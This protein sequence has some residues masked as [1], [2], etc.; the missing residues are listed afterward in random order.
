M[1]GGV[2][3]AGSGKNDFRSTLADEREDADSGVAES[4]EASQEDAGHEGGQVVNV[5]SGNGMVASGKDSKTMPSLRIEA[6]VQDRGWLEPV[7]AG[8]VAG[9]TGKNLNL[10][11]LGVYLDGAPG[12]EVMIR[13]HVS[14]IGWQDWIN[15]GEAAGTVGKNLPIEA[16]QISLTGSVM[17]EFDVWYRVHSADFDWGGW[18]SSGASAGSQGFAKATQTVET[19]L[20]PKGRG[21]PGDTANAI[22]APTV[23]WS[24]YNSAVGWSGSKSTSATPSFTLGT[25]GRSRSLEA[26]T[27]SL[28]GLDLGSVTYAAHVSNIG[29]QNSVADGGMV[30]TVGRGLSVE[31]VRIGLSG[32]LAEV[33]DIWYRVHVRNIGWLGWTENGESAGTEGLATPIEAVEVRILKKGSAAP[34]GGTVFLD[35]LVVTYSAFCAGI[36][37]GSPASNSAAA[38]TTG[39][40]GALEAF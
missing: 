10:E 13:A 6:H 23:V 15:Q 16:I 12:S 24:S 11:G 27:I 5:D 3:E 30:G 26:F 22:R 25:T 39:Q 2:P 20:V 17:D 7:G 32:D 29:W 35:K 19:R 28:P 38:G 8:I 34:G 36:G 9:T 31:A 14:S 4:L 21:A 1:G 33:Y 18:A 37:W 40:V